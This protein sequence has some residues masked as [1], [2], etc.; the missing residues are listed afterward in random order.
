VVVSLATRPPDA[1][2]VDPLTIKR[3]RNDMGN[4]G[5]PQSRTADVALSVLLVGLVAAVWLYFS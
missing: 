2:R 5:A 1:A 3:Y 4:A